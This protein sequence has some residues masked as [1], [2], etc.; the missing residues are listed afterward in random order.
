MK[1]KKLTALIVFTLILQLLLPGYFLSHHFSVRSFAMNYSNDYKFRLNDLHIYDSEMNFWIDGYVWDEKMSVSIDSE[2]FAVISD[3][4]KEK[5]DC[6]FDGDFYR[7]SCWVSSDKIVYEPGVD[8]EALKS[9]IRKTY[10]WAESIFSE[11]CEAYVV[12]KVY[13]GVFIPTAV[14]VDGEKVIT[15][16]QEN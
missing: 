15:I 13:K 11:K 9:K 2:G 3:Y 12:A 6:W 5:G 7:K 1:N 10:G 16:L 8:I 4:A 14:Y